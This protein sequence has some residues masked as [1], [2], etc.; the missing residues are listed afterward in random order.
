MAIKYVFTLQKKKDLL[1][2][3]MAK[4]SVA[5]MSVYFIQLLSVLDMCQMYLN[6]TPL[7]SMCLLQSKANLLLMSLSFSP[8]LFIIQLLIC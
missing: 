1:K 3:P 4:W 7:F 2:E 8:F 5:E 6:S